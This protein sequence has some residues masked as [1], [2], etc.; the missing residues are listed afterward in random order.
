[1]S[2]NGLNLNG[3]GYVIY[4]YTVRP[5]NSKYLDS[6]Q[7]GISELLLERS[8]WQRNEPLDSEQ[9]GSIPKVC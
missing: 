1:M 7:P 3:Q 8:F 6:K 2:Y 5:E 9:P 4:V